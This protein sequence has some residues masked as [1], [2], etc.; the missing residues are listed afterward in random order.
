MP[1]LADNEPSNHI[2][3][4]AEMLAKVLEKH[5][6]EEIRDK[7]MTLMMKLDKSSD[8]H[9]VCAAAYEMFDLFK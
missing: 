2:E 3:V 6:P 9:K 4:K 7:A 1:L 5:K 8:A